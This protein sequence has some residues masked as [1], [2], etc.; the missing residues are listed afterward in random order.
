MCSMLII[1]VGT[2]ASCSARSITASSRGILKAFVLLLLIGLP[3]WRCKSGVA[4]GAQVVQPHIR[5]LA[6]HLV[7]KNVKTLIHN[8]V[9]YALG[10][11][12]RADA[13]ADAIAQRLA[14]HVA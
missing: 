4:P 6:P 2:L 12:L 7:R 11:H 3:D 9:V 1:N 10:H 14:D 13:G 5:R 8:G